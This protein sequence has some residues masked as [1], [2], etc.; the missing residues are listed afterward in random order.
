ME[1]PR[2]SRTSAGT[3][4]AERPRVSSDSKLPITRIRG[5]Q[6]R[7]V[8]TT[9]SSSRAGRRLSCALQ[10]AI[11]VCA[12]TAA[13]EA[14]AT[15]V[16]PPAPV[17]AAPAPVAPAPPP[18]PPPVNALAL[19]QA[20]KKALDEAGESADK[21]KKAPEPEAELK[22]L[23]APQMIKYGVAVG[24]GAALI[25]PVGR[26]NVD[27]KSTAVTAMPYLA[28]HPAYHALGKVTREYCAA[29]ALTLDRDKAQTVA[30]RYAANKAK[31]AWDAQLKKRAADKA[32]Q[33]YKTAGGDSNKALQEAERQ[34]PAV[35]RLEPVFP[36]S[37][38]DAFK[39]H[40]DQW[41]PDGKDKGKDSFEEFPE[42][43]KLIKLVSGWDIDLAGRC[44]STQFGVYFGIPVPYSANF[45]DADDVPDTGKQAPARKRD[46][47]SRG[48]IGIVWA[49]IPY[50]NV[51]AGM[52]SVVADMPVPGEAETHRS[53]S[54][55]Q[56]TFALG[57]TVDIIGALVG[58]K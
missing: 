21:T 54:S 7:P 57:G 49:P 30:N 3:L 13:A 39:K 55:W 8:T 38:L 16:L 52:S 58:A 41:K 43:K 34:N 18:A 5:S 36:S 15:P 45:T 48:S 25:T 11:N 35:A 19:E 26:G 33:E 56:L 32:E 46:A 20:F 10:L 6:L 14:P 24:V 27:Q 23:T 22:Y 9:H 44:V 1:A 28:W 12:T 53:Q 17:P 4:E 50:F 47:R 2:A 29:R 42:R 51:L 37:L 31:L 40:M